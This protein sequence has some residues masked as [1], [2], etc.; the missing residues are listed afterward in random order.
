[1]ALSE[2]ERKKLAELAA[3]D[4][5]EMIGTLRESN[6]KSEK[7]FAEERKKIMSEFLNGSSSDE[8]AETD[9]DDMIP[10]EKNQYFQRLKKRV[11]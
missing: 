5:I 2:E 1:M 7:K 9:S 3:D 6:E 4:L 10:L 8:E 11:F